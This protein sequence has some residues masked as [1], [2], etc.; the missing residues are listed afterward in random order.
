VQKKKET[1]P[2]FLTTSRIGLGRTS[3]TEAFASARKYV[4]AGIKEI[5]YADAFVP[6]HKYLSVWV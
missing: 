2:F 1:A 5:L 4:A 6:V 3:Y